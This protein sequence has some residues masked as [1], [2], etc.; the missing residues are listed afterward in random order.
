M[1]GF[2]FGTN[3]TREAP[4]CTPFTHSVANT[5]FPLNRISFTLRDYP[6]ARI[7]GLLVETA[8][9]VRMNI[10]KNGSNIIFL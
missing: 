3:E 7:A 9:E 6:A 4:F 8:R 10:K 5:H 2:K 1:F